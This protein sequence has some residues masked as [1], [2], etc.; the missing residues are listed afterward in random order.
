MTDKM[1]LVL[2]SFVAAC[3]WSCKADAFLFLLKENLTQQNHGKKLIYTPHFKKNNYSSQHHECQHHPALSSSRKDFIANTAG[4]FLALPSSFLLQC[5]EEAAATIQDPKTGI[6]LPSEG[7]IED[8][9]PKD[10]KNVD[11]PFT[12]RRLFTRLDTSPDSVFYTDPRFVEHIDEN[13]VQLLTDY[14]SNHA[15]AEQTDGCESVLDLCSSWTSHITTSR[16]KDLKR[17]A[18]VGMN[19]QELEANPVLTEWLIQDLNERPKLPFEDDSFDIVLCQLSIDYLTRPLEVLKET[20][21]VLR[22][23]GT[24][25]ILFSNRL[26]LSKAVALWTGADD[27][28]HA[29]TVACYLHFCGCDTKQDATAPSDAS[30]S[31]FE[32]NIQ[33]VDL[34]TERRI[35]GDPLYVVKGTKAKRSSSV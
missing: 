31:C 14:V 5:P 27:V 8:S 16:A 11:N 20:Q 28:D 12:D 18:G 10:W 7:E 22:P 29:Y 2:M 13:A 23:G 24:I 25:H 6:L 3:W 21:R 26:F 32:I 35:I 30:G 1:K 17:I 33:A 9:I 19:Q 4:V 15:I 34:S